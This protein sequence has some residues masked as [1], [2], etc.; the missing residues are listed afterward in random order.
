MWTLF[1]TAIANST[2]HDREGMEEQ[3]IQHLN[4]CRN[5]YYS[6]ANQLIESVIHPR[7]EVNQKTFSQAVASEKS[8]KHRQIHKTSNKDSSQCAIFVQ[9]KEGDG[10]TD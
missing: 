2:V 8:S 3:F 5:R 6:V 4:N 9:S 7:Q 1:K 10:R